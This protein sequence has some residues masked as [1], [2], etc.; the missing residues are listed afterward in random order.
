MTSDSDINS[1]IEGTMK[2]QALQSKFLVTAKGGCFGVT[3]GVLGGCIGGA[4]GVLGGYFI[5]KSSWVI[6]ESF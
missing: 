1:F 3:F 6:L 5:L 4:W 2:K